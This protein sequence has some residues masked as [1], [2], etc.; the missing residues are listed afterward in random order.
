MSRPTTSAEANPLKRPLED[1]AS[2]DGVLWAVVL[3]SDG[4]VVESVSKINNDHLDMISGAACLVLE[5]NSRIGQDLG[6]GNLQ[7]VL[8]D[9]DN[10][11]LFIMSL[12]S[13]G[14]FLIV[15]TEKRVNVSLAKY[16]LEKAKA[17]LDSAI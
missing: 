1:V 9:F 7:Y 16:A 5:A 13:G 11:R 12:K 14:A 4:L 8:S 15:H 6:C 17:L 2:I 3:D 10:G